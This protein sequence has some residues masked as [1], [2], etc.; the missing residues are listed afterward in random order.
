MASA[1]LD[2]NQCAPENSVGRKKQKMPDCKKSAVCFDFQ[3]GVCK[4]GAGCKFCHES[5]STTEN[6]NNS[7]SVEC[8][9]ARQPEHP[10]NENDGKVWQIASELITAQPATIRWEML[11][12]LCP[13]YLLGRYRKRAR[14]VP[15][16][17]WTVEVD[18]KISSR[19]EDKED[20]EVEDVEGDEDGDIKSRDNANNSISNNN[21]KSNSKITERKGRN[22]VEEIIGDAVM[23]TLQCADYKMHSCGREDID[24]RYVGVLHCATINC[25]LFYLCVIASSSCEESSLLT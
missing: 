18:A 21:S 25:S 11:I 13:V 2:R 20:R 4:R 19:E 22:S 6:G 10:S 7:G 24:V 3:K 16:S 17:P 1:V 23:R 5:I 9:M 12:T 15:Q 14:D 8:E